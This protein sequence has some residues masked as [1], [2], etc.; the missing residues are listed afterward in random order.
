M[1]ISRLGSNVKEL[2]PS[3]NGMKTGACDH[4]FVAK[5]AADGS[6]IEW[7]RHLKGPSNAPKL[8][9]LNDG[10]LQ[11]TAQDLRNL[12]PAGEELGKLVIPGGLSHLIAI[13]PHASARPFPALAEPSP[14]TQTNPGA[15]HLHPRAANN[16]SS[17]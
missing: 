14:A 17:F 8:E 16:A 15:S 11:F 3:D 4:T 12:S 7:A 10:S 6:R 1:E 5:V 13:N 2:A 9:I